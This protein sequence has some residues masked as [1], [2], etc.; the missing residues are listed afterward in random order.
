MP[1]S[2]GTSTE[3]ILLVLGVRREA[4]VEGGVLLRHGLLHGP[5]PPSSGRLT[6]LALVLPTHLPSI[7]N[8]N[9][10]LQPGI[11]IQPAPVRGLLHPS[12]YRSYHYGHA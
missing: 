1:R 7:Y 11:S 2:S 9:S 3:I 8:L 12:Q 6:P 5:T 10:Q 4:S